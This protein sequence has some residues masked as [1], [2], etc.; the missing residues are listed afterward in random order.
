MGSTVTNLGKKWTRGSRGH[1]VKTRGGKK[2]RPDGG[3]EERGGA[4]HGKSFLG[5]WWVVG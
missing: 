5:G 3:Q 1:M 2:E 4:P